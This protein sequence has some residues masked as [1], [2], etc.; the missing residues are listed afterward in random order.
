MAEL[1]ELLDE[2]L[3]EYLD[4]QRNELN[5]GQASPTSVVSGRDE[6][7][8]RPFRDRSVEARVKVERRGVPSGARGGQRHART[9]TARSPW[10]GSSRYLRQ[11]FLEDPA[12]R[13]EVANL[14]AVGHDVLLT[15]WDLG[16]EGRTSRVAST[17][18]AA[19]ADRVPPRTLARSTTTSKSCT[20]ETSRAIAKV[21]P[22]L[23]ISIGDGET[24][25]TS[26]S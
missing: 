10:R 25:T 1:G 7:R 11:Q 8:L 20:V 15:E 22:S 13:R 4:R 18:L 16:V 24:V 17:S 26:R 3:T 19:C 6:R 21:F 12:V 2:A 14:L 9:T 23:L 5:E